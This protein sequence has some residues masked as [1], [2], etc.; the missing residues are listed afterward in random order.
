M[1]AKNHGMVITV[2]SLAAYVTAPNLVDY[3]ASKAAALVFHEGLQVCDRLSILA[4]IVT[5]LFPR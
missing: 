1:I 4:D 3:T 2:A 5:N